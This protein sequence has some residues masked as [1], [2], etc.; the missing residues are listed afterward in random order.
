MTR[1]AKGLLIYLDRFLLENPKRR[2][3]LCKFF[4][5]TTGRELHKGE[6]W[7][8]VKQRV[9]PNLSTSLIYLAFLHKHG[10]IT[11]SK[12]AGD[13]FEYVKPERLKK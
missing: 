8:H 6:L 9:E 4:E 5:K 12:T 7:K 2:R 10:A 13:L 3:E 1:A 11:P